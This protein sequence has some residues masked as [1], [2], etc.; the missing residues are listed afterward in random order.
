MVAARGTRPGGEQQRLSCLLMSTLVGLEW[1]K[2]H[3]QRLSEDLRMQVVESQGKAE[4]CRCVS[5]RVCVCV[6]ARTRA[7]VWAGGKA[8]IGILPHQDKHSSLVQGYTL[9]APKK[10]KELFLSSCRLSIFASLNLTMRVGY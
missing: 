2:L 9:L 8:A 4:N 3:M 10:Y 5:V 7:C 6:R 1:L